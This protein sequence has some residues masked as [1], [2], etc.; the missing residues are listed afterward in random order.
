MTDVSWLV[1]VLISA[2]IHPL[3]DFAFKGAGSPIACYFGYTAVWICLGFAQALI[4]GHAL[5]LPVDVWPLLLNSALGL[6][7]YYVGTL[8]ALKR[9]DLSVYYPIIRSSPVVVL[10][11]SWAI[12][13][14]SFNWMVVVG[15]GLV[16]VGTMLL[17]KP[18]GGLLSDPRSLLLALMAMIGSASYTLSDAE[19]MQSVPPSVYLFYTYL[20]VGPSLGLILLWQHRTETGVVG[21]LLEGWRTQPWRILFS[22]AMAYSSYL[23]ILIAFQNGASAA[24]VSAVRQASIPISVILG[25]MILRETSMMRRLQWS[26]VLALG[27]ILIGL[28]EES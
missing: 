22:G 26:G 25:A 10:A 19:A 28:F 2:A 18:K 16:F 11:V 1:L 27:I 17:Q 3:R 13:G 6:V 8:T 21:K 4:V 20:I 14:Q 12:F 23:L 9:G 5:V 15:V 7:L 24:P